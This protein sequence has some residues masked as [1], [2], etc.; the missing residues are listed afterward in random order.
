MLLQV[1]CECKMF[2]LWSFRISADT[3]GWLWIVWEVLVRFLNSALCVFLRAG[4]VAT[5]GPHCGK[6]LLGVLFF[7]CFGWTLTCFHELCILVGNTFEY[8]YDYSNELCTGSNICFCS[9]NFRTIWHVFVWN[10]GT[11][12]SMDFLCFPTCQKRLSRF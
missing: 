3:A 9:C 8:S 12:N 7:W 1:R 5:H 11:Q 10:S 4:F 2:L 6:V